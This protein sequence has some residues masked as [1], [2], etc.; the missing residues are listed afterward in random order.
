LNKKGGKVNSDYK[1]EIRGILLV[2]LFIMVVPLIFYPK[3]LGIKWHTSFLLLF[4]LELGWYM[5]V[6][7]FMFTRASA[8]IVVLAA[9][10]TLG[11]RIGL[12]IGFGFLLLAMFSLPLSF[13]LKL[14][15]YQYTPAF[16]FQVLM[17]PFALKSLFGGFMKKTTK[18]EQDL[19]PFKKKVSEAVLSSFTPGRTKDKIKGGGSRSLEKEIKLAKG[20][21]LEN[22]LHY[23]REYAG[24]KAAILVDHEGLV[25]VKDSSSDLDCDEVASFARCLKEGNDQILK[26][27]GEKNS[28][29]I[30]IYTSDL[31]ISLNQIESFLLLV[32]SDRHTDELLSVRILQSTGMLKRFLA[33][34]YQEKA[35]KAVE[36]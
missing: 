7:F 1:G 19:T 34:R 35:L 17:S 25:V 23:L 13:A 16:L 29:R 36:G 31:W 32:V 4:A 2:S 21:S 5:L 6:F 27:I 28:E 12:G 3:D 20:D 24:V 8:L 30:G 22:I 11:Y 10:L 9:T 15:I 33:Q 18:A 14:G 26:K